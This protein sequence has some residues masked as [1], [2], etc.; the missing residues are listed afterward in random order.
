MWFCTISLDRQTD[1]ALCWRGQRSFWRLSPVGLLR[2][3][4]PGS[5][6]P[7][8]APG[9]KSDPPSQLLSSPLQ[10]NPSSP[11]TVHTLANQ[12]TNDT[13]RKL[14]A[15]LP[16]D[17]LIVCFQKVHLKKLRGA[18]RPSASQKPPSFSSRRHSV[19]EQRERSRHRNTKTAP[20]GP[21]RSNAPGVPRCREE[22]RLRSPCPNCSIAWCPPTG[23]TS[24][25]GP[26]G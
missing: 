17:A 14:A 5:Q 7:P 25:S 15:S 9:G 20:S 19:T 23:C 8:Q 4:C 10:V 2:S 6:V 21:R 22:S 13:N 26:S 11:K 18:K 3:S 16:K 12:G 1:S 24:A